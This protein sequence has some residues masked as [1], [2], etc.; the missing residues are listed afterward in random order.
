MADSKDN[1]CWGPR[2]KRLVIKFSSRWSDFEIE[3]KTKLR[4]CKRPQEKNKT[5]YKSS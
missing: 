2:S 1:W 4:Q 5:K 3:K